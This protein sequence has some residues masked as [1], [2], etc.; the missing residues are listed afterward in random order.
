MIFYIYHI[1]NIQSIKSLNNYYLYFYLNIEQF[2]KSCNNKRFLQLILS[3]SCL[4][5]MELRI[6][7]I[8]KS[9]LKEKTQYICSI[10][11]FYC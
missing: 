4:M 2:S 11:L 6:S 1:L 9:P 8:C 7:A 3:L 5:V 10:F